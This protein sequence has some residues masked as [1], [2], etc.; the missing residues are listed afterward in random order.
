MLRILAYSMVLAGSLP[1]ALPAFA[2]DEKI[3]INTATYEEITAISG[4]TEEI[5]KKL[6][7]T[8]KKWGIFKT[9]MNY[10]KSKALLKIY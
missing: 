6:L 7:N 1:L 9:L 4:M 2:A 8:V 3:S 10:W 5:A